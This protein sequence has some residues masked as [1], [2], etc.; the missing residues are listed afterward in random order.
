[1]KA[2]SNKIIRDLKLYTDI[3]RYRVNAIVFYEGFPA[4]Y[5]LIVK[6][7][8]FEVTKSFNNDST[9]LQGKDKDG[10]LDN[11]STTN[12]VHRRRYKNED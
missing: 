9:F 8:Q 2:L 6:K 7:G 5:V 12:K 3:V 1:M 4:D 11:K 10:P